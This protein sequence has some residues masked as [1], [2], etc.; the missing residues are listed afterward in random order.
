MAHC[1]LLSCYA[2][3][4]PTVASVLVLFLKPLPVERKIRIFHYLHK[5][6]LQFKELSI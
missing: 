1:V 5:S 4:C 3:L 2:S 6:E